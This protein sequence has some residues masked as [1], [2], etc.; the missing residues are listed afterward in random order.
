VARDVPFGHPDF[1]GKWPCPHPCHTAERLARLAKLSG[2]AEEDLSLRLA[3]FRVGDG[4]TKSVLRAARAFLVQPT[5]LFY[6]WGGYGNG[7][8]LLLKALVNEF[9]AAGYVAVYTKFS[10]LLWWMR[11]VFGDNG[12]Q[13]SYLGRYERLKRVPMLAVDEFDK[14]NLTDFAQEFRFDFF[15]ERYEAG[16]RGECYTVFASNSAPE[17][18]PGYL[19]SRIEDGRC[20][21]VKNE[22]KDLR[23]NLR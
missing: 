8:S 17:D 18:L 2:L 6:L 10:R 5:P 9:N 15:D 7:K 3:D 14:V 20:L 22:C 1:D 11:Q 13:E 4:V 21:I 19:L 23:P 16:L 12:D